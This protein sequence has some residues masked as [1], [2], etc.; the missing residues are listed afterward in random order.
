MKRFIGLRYGAISMAICA[1]VA[2]V[3]SRLTSLSFWA[4]FA[5]WFVALLVNGLIAAFE[6]I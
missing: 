4:I 6:D 3:V 1:I 2:L 5:I